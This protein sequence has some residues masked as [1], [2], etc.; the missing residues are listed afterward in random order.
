VEWEEPDGS[1]GYYKSNEG[2]T[3][4]QEPQPDRPQR[5]AKNE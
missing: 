4:S 2:N 1:R 3:T 5:R